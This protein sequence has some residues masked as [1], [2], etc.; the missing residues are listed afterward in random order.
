MARRST[1][2]LLAWVVLGVIG[3][4]AWGLLADRGAARAQ[5]TGAPGRGAEVYAVH[6]AACHGPTGQGGRGE[7]VQAG[8]ALRGLEVAL[9]DQQVR[10]GRMPIVEPSVGVDGPEVL[11]AQDREAL[12]AWMAERMELTGDV[13][14]VAQGDAARGHELY[15]IHCAACHGSLGTGGVGAAGTII[16]GVLGHDR[17]AHVEAIRTG[18]Y[19]MPRFDEGVLSDQ[20]AADVATFVV[21]ALDGAPRTPL[22]LRE[23]HRV[24]MWGMAGVLAVGLLALVVLLGRSVPAPSGDS[25]GG[26]GKRR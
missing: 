25:G 2:A 21:E 8:P 13:P 17:T 12:V 7:G 26:R 10:T 22:G 1:G 19:D 6:C 5:Q 16:P 18:P 3:A 4:A 9:V 24:T 11:A 15:G 20:D 14:R 23:M